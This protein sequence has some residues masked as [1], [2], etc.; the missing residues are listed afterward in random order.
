MWT[1]KELKDRAKAGLKRNYWKSVLF[2]F[3]VSLIYAGT[4]ANGK[5][6]VDDGTLTETLTNIF[7]GMT[8][9]EIVVSLVFLA[10]AVLTGCLISAVF[11]AVIYNPLKIGIS[12]FCLEALHGTADLNAIS[13][14]YKPKL[15]SKIWILFLRDLSVVLWGCLFIIPGIIKSYEYSQVTYILSENPDIS[16]KEALRQSKAMMK[17]NKWKAFVLDLSFLGWDILSM[18]TFGI[19]GI[20]YVEPYKMLT[21]AALY[22]TLKH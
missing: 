7:S 10:G 6:S 20:F 17:G 8:P 15:I 19:L 21:S 14:G 5:S 1:R 9:E 13:C 22:E 18:I 16:A 11:H 2:G 12:G 4:A 3:I